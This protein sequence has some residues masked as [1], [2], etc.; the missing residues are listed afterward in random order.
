MTPEEI[1]VELNRLEALVNDAEQKPGHVTGGRAT[2]ALVSSA[3]GCLKGHKLTDAQFVRLQ[4][5][6]DRSN[7][8]LKSNNMKA[9][10]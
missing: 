6:F 3:Q 5:L 10:P 7:A 9:K 1:D 4:S 8:T 2:I